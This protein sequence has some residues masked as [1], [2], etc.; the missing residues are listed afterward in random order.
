MWWGH[1]VGWGGWLAMTL[2]MAGFWAV[3]AILVIAVLRG[4]WPGA[5]RRADARE[6]LRARLAR[7]EIDVEEY[8]RCLDALGR[9]DP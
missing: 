6:I 9:T 8:E 7:G 5:D 2:G 3:L 1:D 4:G